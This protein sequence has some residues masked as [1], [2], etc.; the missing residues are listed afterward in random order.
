LEIEENLEV[1]NIN[2]RFTFH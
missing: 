1:Q 2:S